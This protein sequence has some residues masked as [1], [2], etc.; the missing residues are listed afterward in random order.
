[1]RCEKCGHELKTGDVFC[2]ICGTAIR[3]VGDYNLLENDILPEILDETKKE[4]ARLLAAEKKE[5]ENAEKKR[6]RK[7]TTLISVVIIVCACAACLL[8]YLHSASYY[9]HAGD[10]ALSDKNYKLALS[11]YS[12]AVDAKASEPA[13]IGCG[14][15]EY[16]LKDYEKAAAYFQ[17]ALSINPKSTAAYRDL[18]I[19]YS[20]A[21]D[22]D[23][24]EN[25]SDLAITSAQ[26]SLYAEYQTPSPEFSVP[27]GSYDDDVTVELTSPDGSTVYYTIDGSYPSAENGQLYVEPFDVADGTTTVKAVCISPSGKAGRIV[28]ETYTVTYTAPE[29]PVV[30][31]SEGT[32]TKPTMVTMTAENPEDAIY[33]TWDGSIP[34]AASSRYTGP[35]PIPSGNHVLTVIAIDSH[36]MTSDVYR[37][38]LIYLGN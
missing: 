30:S 26:K 11:R 4:N 2:P 15:S 32:F 6:K 14:K 10:A 5:R 23:A 24:I 18:L 12:S 1:M 21:S 17:K 13:Y 7:K 37:C 27:G 29:Q 34:T 9:L 16:Y 38:N 35:V 33:Y 36:N 8:L 25:S 20:A 19:V 22:F 28:S 3:M 31:P